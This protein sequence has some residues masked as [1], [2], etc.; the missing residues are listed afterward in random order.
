MDII[1]KCLAVKIL[2]CT[3][4]SSDTSSTVSVERGRNSKQ[5]NIN[6]S[7]PKQKKENM[8]NLLMS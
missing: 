3:D 1:F 5:C 4:E 2:D 8:K 7:N 6:S